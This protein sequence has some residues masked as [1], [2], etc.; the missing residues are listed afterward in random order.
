MMIDALYDELRS[1][2]RAQLTVHVASCLDCQERLGRLRS[3]LGTLDQWPDP[4]ATGEIAARALR[5][6]VADRVRRPS[7]ARHGAALSQALRRLSAG[8]RQARR[9]NL[10]GVR[11]ETLRT[12]AWLAVTGAAIA[13]G[14]RL[15][16][17]VSSIVDICD[18]WIHTSLG[19]LPFAVALL[20]IATASSAGPLFVGAFVFLRQTRTDDF[21]ANA[22]SFAIYAAI[23]TPL[24][25]HQCLSLPLGVQGLWI[26]GTVLG[27]ALGGPPTA[28]WV[29]RRW[30]LRE[31]ST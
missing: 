24:V 12:A 29:R 22:M 11:Q 27:V 9:R 10:I 14:L 28:R 13:V 30:A 21:S 23:L 6:V 1:S 4:P 19:L 18:R 3:V 25:Y 26:V 15:W 31:N 8:V 20:F 16:L 17:P 7:S 2:E 5:R